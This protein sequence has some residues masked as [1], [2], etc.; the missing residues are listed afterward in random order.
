MLTLLAISACR[1]NQLLSLLTHQ[2]W[3]WASQLYCAC[4]PG[5]V[6]QTFSFIY[7]PIGF[8]LQGRT[9]WC[10][11][12]F[13]LGFGAFF[14][15]STFTS[16]SCDNQLPSFQLCSL[17]SAFCHFHPSSFIIFFFFMCLWYGMIYFAW[18]AVGKSGSLIWVIGLLVGLSRTLKISLFHPRKHLSMKH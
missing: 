5:T 11:S 10:L 12:S 4:F 15:H 13:P 9:K 14:Y 16:V 6:V 2:F 18:S 7:Y 1:E 8:V 17:W 3:W